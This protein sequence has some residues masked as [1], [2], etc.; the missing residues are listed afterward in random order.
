[1]SNQNQKHKQWDLATTLAQ[2]HLDLT[3]E[4]LLKYQKL[5]ADLEHLMDG[6]DILSSGLLPH[7]I[8]PLDKLAEPLDHM[9]RKFT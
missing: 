3:R 7:T 1:M 2:L 6:L 8:I 4:I 9:K 5:L